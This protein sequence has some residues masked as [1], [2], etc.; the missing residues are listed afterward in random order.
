MYS[1]RGRILTNALQ[2]LSVY[3]ILNHCIKRR[4]LYQP[5]ALKVDHSCNKY[6]DLIG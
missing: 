4:L 6:C 3:V 5:N 2:L 1:D